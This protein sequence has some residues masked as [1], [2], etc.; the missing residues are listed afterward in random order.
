M[1]IFNGKTLL[2]GALAGLTAFML[3]MG[4]SAQPFF[5]TFLYAASALPILIVGLGWGNIAAIIAI[6]VAGI[7]GVSFASPDFALIMIVV[8][9]APAGWLSH[10]GNLARP[11]S[12][13]G[14]PEGLLAWYPLSDIL[15]HLCAIV[16]LALVIVGYRAGYGPGLTDQVVDAMMQT[17]SSQ[18]P[19]LAVTDADVDKIKQ[20]IVLL[21]PLV[22]GA[23]WVLLLFVAFHFATRITAAA[24]I[25]LRPREDV[26]AALRMPRLGL[27]FIV[28]AV[29]AT[30]L[31]GTIAMIGAAATGA[32][33][34]G[35]LLAGL[36]RLHFAARGKSWATP[37]IILAYLSL[38]FGFPA[39]IFI[40]LGI[41]DTRRA[42]S[43][44]PASG[45]T[46]NSEH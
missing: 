37:A 44:T 39:L 43:M 12:E 45:K 15:L 42:L 34:G 31:G 22:Q 28:V 13:L 18:D 6:A 7:L 8:T 2:L 4:A 26:S 21:L 20:L 40:G 30:F 23:T 11:A 35:F 16:T 29:V 10:L 24:G 41:T 19:S 1:K 46:D 14:G 5:S 36:A 38:M 25:S 27:V 33:C 9:L 32:F 3:V 17:L